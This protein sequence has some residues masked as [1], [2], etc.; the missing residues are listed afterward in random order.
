MCIWGYNIFQSINQSETIIRCLHGLSRDDRGCFVCECLP[1]VM[2]ED[3]E[4]GGK[5]GDKCKSLDDT[6]CEK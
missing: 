4:G 5:G 1:P 6:N 2:A 3:G